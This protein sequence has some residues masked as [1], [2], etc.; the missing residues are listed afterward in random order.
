MHTLHRVA[1]PTLK[2]VGDK[3]WSG[4]TVCRVT[5]LM[6]CLLPPHFQALR[7]ILSHLMSCRSPSLICLHP[8]CLGTVSVLDLILML[9]FVA[10]VRHLLCPVVFLLGN[11]SLSCA[12]V[13]LFTHLNY[14]VFATQKQTGDSWIPNRQRWPRC[15]ASYWHLRSRPKYLFS[16]IDWVGLLITFEPLRCINSVFY[17]CFP[18]A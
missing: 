15:S 8:L 7:G 2:T 10:G 18:V 3:Y 17:E 9:F 1:V 16:F 6:Q 12:R 11:K 14:Y 13:G 4:L 5:A